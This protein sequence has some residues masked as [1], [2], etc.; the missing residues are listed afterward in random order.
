MA[1]IARSSTAP[2]VRVKP[3]EWL[4]EKRTL[5]RPPDR[6]RVIRERVAETIAGEAR[7]G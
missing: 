3:L 2:V 1:A 6:E 5:P 4:R 7:T